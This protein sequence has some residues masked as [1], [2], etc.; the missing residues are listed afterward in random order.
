MESS[1]FDLITNLNES[2]SDYE[3]IQKTTN[4]YDVLGIS[5]FS[6]QD[7][8]KKEYKRLC[9]LFHPDKTSQTNSDIFQKIENA[10]H[11][12][13]DPMR[14][15]EYD[16]SSLKQQTSSTHSS[17]N[18]KPGPPDGATYF[19]K[20]FLID[21]KSIRSFHLGYIYFFI[22]DTNG[23]LWKLWTRTQF[24]CGTISFLLPLLQQTDS[25]VSATELLKNDL[26]YR[27]RYSGNHLF[28]DASSNGGAT[29]EENERTIQK[30]GRT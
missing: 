17:G 21:L 14:R 18:Y 19:F 11:T 2:K 28:R 9:L 16:S 12:L 20:V 6:T 15:R 25:L 7:E 26:Q 1:L 13:N 29:K 22:L 4:H 5:K 10:Y 3:R 24:V 23:A 30:C 27:N 8:I